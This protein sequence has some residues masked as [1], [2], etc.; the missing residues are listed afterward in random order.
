M[1]KLAIA[2]AVAI[3]L[4]VMLFLLVPLMREPAFIVPWLDGFEWS[5]TGVLST[6]VFA[7]L[8]GK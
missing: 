4:Y 1:T 7:G 5:F 8:M 6:A 3:G 2:L